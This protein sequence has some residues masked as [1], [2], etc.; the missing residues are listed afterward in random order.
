MLAI[1]RVDD[2]FAKIVQFLSIGMEPHK[3]T[4]IQKKQLVVRDA[5]F[6]LIVEKLYNM[7]PDEIPRRCVMDT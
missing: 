1:G 6:L 5:D 7:G 4:I 2:H 3:Y